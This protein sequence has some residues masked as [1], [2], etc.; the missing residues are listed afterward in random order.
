[1][2]AAG[3][4]FAG[5]QHWHPGRCAPDDRRGAFALRSLVAC[6]LR[7][8]ADMEAIRGPVSNARGAEA[9]QPGQG[10]GCAYSSIGRDAS[11]A[12]Q[13]PHRYS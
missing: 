13:A 10:C 8:V 6:A 2:A 7:R 1:M 3:L 5:V 12:P 4:D 9:P 11:K